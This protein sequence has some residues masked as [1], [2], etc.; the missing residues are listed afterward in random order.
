ILV[1]FLAGCVAAITVSRSPLGR[2]MRAV[3]E[4]PTR[5][6]SLGQRNY[7]VRLVA[8]VFAGALAGAAGTTW[9][10]E[11]GFVSPSDISFSISA[12]A[13]LCVVLGGAGPLLGPIVAAT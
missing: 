2:S 10:V 4:S 6:T 8:Y 13:W 3:R 11:A 7:T 1:T 12:L 5:M 9:T